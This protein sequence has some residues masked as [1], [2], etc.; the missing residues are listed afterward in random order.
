MA[1]TVIVNKLT[2]SHAGSNG[3]SIAFPDFCKTP[4]P[5]GPIPIPYPNVAKSSDTADGSKT[6]KMDGSPIMLKG[7]N[8][9][10]STGDEAGSAMGINSNMIKGKAQFVSYSFDVKVD[11]KNVCRLTDPTQ[12]NIGS[13]NTL[14][15]AHFQ[16]PLHVSDPQM[17]A[18]EENKKKEEEE[19]EKKKS[20][21]T[22]WENSG[23]FS[24]HRAAFKKV[25]NQRKIIIFIRSG[26]HWCVDN[27]WIPRH[28]QPKPHDVIN[29]NTIKEGN[30]EEFRKWLIKYY[31][32]QTLMGAR[33]FGIEG[34]GQRADSEHSEAMKKSPQTTE[35]LKGQTPRLPLP[36]TAERF[37]GIVMDKKDGEPLTGY[38]KGT[39]GS[40][41]GK[42]I[43]GDYDLMDV[44]KVG[45]NCLRP[46][47]DAV[48]GQI[49]VEL[50]KEM[51]WDGI[52]HGPQSLWVSKNPK[53]N[54][55]QELTNYLK[56]DLKK[57]PKIQI[58]PD[59]DP[60]PV[61]DN[62]LTVVGPDEYVVYFE[63]DEDVKNALMCC[64]CARRPTEEELD[65]KEWE[66]KGL[67]KGMVRRWRKE[68]GDWK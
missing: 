53:V 7:S 29:A 52:Q 57:P 9:R 67:N 22:S 50:N 44:F 25:A 28:H 63:S 60:F 6:V 14:A 23:V 19:E 34:H 4:T 20:E 41:K 55:P 59:R 56:S 35:K 66:E 46:N 16:G 1:L 64:G 5:G 49:R 31:K 21:E 33:M 39:S 18:C 30:I 54:F 2:V 65:E 43:T 8:M 26:N 42:W 37:F 11:G 38:G 68:S 10:M 62:K 24:G 27:K 40:Y 45:G 17:K 47:N 12:Q 36:E 58:A 13:F 61:C 32:D 15:P 3:I 51:G 48:F